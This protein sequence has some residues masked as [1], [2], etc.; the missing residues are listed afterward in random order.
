MSALFSCQQ[1]KVLDGVLTYIYRSM[2]INRGQRLERADRLIDNATGRS[3]LIARKR[4]RPRKRS[5]ISTMDMHYL[6]LKPQRYVPAQ[7]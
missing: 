7:L 2:V 4:M 5:L 6:P 1:T 3:R